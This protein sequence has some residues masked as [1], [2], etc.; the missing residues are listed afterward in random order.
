MAELGWLSVIETTECFGMS[1]VALSRILNG[2]S[3]IKSI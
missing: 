1:C 3:V 2:K